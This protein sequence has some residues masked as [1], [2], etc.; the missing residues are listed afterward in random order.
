MEFPIYL[1]HAATTPTHPAVVEAMLPYFTDCYGN[2]ATLYSVGAM[3]QDAVESARERVAA[4]LNAFPEEILFTSGGTESDNAAIRGIALAHS[5]RG[6][7][8][9]TT[10]IEHHAVLEPME[11]LARCGF[12]VEL[13]PVD[14]EGRVDPDDVARRI[15]P[16]TILVSVMHANN[17]IGTV[18]PIA[19]IG[20]LCRERGVLFHT[21][22]VQTAGK[23][24]I[25]VRALQVDLLSLTAHKFYGPKGVGALYIRRGVR[26]T[27]FQDGG[28]QER[29]RR[30]GTLNVPGIVGMGAAIELALQDREAECQRLRALRD[31]LIQRLMDAIPDVHLCG[32][33]EHRLPH[34]V[35]VCVDG[36][37]G[38][39][40]LLALDA[41]GICV[42]AGSACSSGSTEPSH[43]LR[44]IGVP[45]DR[46]RG[47]L[48]MTLGRSTTQEALDY[49][50]DTLAAVVRD[51]RRLGGVQPV[52]SSASL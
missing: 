23:L 33:R 39:P 26:W 47:A 46:A 42:S 15:R 20:T 40:L 43:V 12:S 37:E 7:H 35:H 48:R 44:A 9:L 17:E 16:D 31:Y 3:A 27:R 45:R 32:S 25:D 28:G 13:L 38:E 29:G 10:P 21:D 22:A 51:L 41:A 18:Q 2:P 4:A 1:D 11:T 14:S 19:E 52:V 34:N 49:T 30:G 5:D 8:L 50:V 24:P 36:V 6:R